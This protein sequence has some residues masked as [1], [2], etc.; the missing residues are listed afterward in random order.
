MSPV[1]PNLQRF[2]QRAD[3]IGRAATYGTSSS[4]FP[5]SPG[6]ILPYFP[7]GTRTS[8]GG[9]PRAGNSVPA[10]PDR[11]LPHRETGERHLG[12]AMTCGGRGE[13]GRI[14]RLLV[15]Q[16]GLYG[17]YEGYPGPW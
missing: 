15:P 17:V 6:L 10:S 7:P 3:N 9:K 1:C 13:E 14:N 2:S 12:A 8:V 4:V 11:F 16:M 5:G